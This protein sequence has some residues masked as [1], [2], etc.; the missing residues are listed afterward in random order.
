MLIVAVSQ[1]NRYVKAVLEEDPKLSDVFVKGEVS[2]F[3]R[4]RVS[5]HCYF[6]LTDDGGSVKAVLF[7]RHAA[8]LEFEPRDGMAVLARASVSVY[9]REGA[10]QLYVTELLPQGA[11]AQS[12][13]LEQR[14]ERLRALGVFDE[15]RKKPLPRFP[16]RVGVVT[17]KSGAALQD[18]RTV[19]ERRW[20]CCLLILAPAAVQGR[21]APASLLRAVDEIDRAGC[22]VF[23]LARGGGA[24]EDL[25]A[26]NDE[27]LVTRVF[28]CKTPVISA[29]GHETDTTLCD[30]A[31]DARAPTPSA[32]AELAVPDRRELLQ[33]VSGYQ[34][35]LATAAGHMLGSRQTA[36]LR[37]EQQPCLRSSL[38]IVKR[39]EKSVD[40][41]TRI[42]YNSKRIFM[43]EIS[44][45]LTSSA[46]L[47][48]SL[49][50][51]R[52]L[53]RG[54]C[55]AFYAG[56]GHHTGPVSR[57]AQLTAGDALTL[58]FCDGEAGVTVERTLSEKKEN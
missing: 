4:H 48:D 42:M 21:D 40:I 19:L 27:A 45:R 31:A 12:I 11:G 1:L 36:L 17:S 41:I 32:A 46:A 52:V 56:E 18:I 54:Y 8:L 55:A 6:R 37:M 47:L 9:E 16:V 53:D 35:R 57:A 34:K 38:E 26:F 5:G 51:L 15:T 28:R 33:R 29:V 10:Y 44:L 23:L 30:Y 58:R 7:A 22:D 13:A 43:Q 2:G 50:P 49:S 20:P 39:C 3:V 25:S 14:K 24:A